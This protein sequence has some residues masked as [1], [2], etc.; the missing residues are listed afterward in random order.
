MANKPNPKELERKEQIENTVSRTEQFFNENKNLIYGILLGILVVGL[1][2]LGYHKYIYR[3][4]CQEAQYQAVA[5]ENA[6]QQGEFE[7]ALN[8]DGNS[9]GFAQVIEDYGAKAGKAVYLYAGVCELQLGNNDSAI[10]YLRK[11]NGK[12][13]I[14]AARAKACLGDAY[15]NLEDYKAAVSSYKHAIK[16]ADNDFAAGYLRKLGGVYE[17]LGDKAA[18]LECYKTIKDKYPASVEAYDIDSF[19]VAVED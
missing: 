19:I 4:K 13:P 9:L 11:Y 16:L 6:F 3:P 1:A 12:E 17:H 18:A 7:I 2:V 8:G 15:V 5:A 14:L 10:A